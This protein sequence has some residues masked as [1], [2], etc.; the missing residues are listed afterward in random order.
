[1][2][3]S[4]SEKYFSED[5]STNLLKISYLFKYFLGQ[6][7]AENSFGVVSS[8]LKKWRYSHPLEFYKSP[9]QT[10]GPAENIILLGDTFGGAS[11]Y[12]ALQSA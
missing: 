6:Q 3:P 11:A 5:D 12:G 4:W 8:Q 9:F 2:Q 7:T 10:V 1:M